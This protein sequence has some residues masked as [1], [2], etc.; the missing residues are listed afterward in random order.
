F[1]KVFSYPH[2]YKKQKNPCSNGSEKTVFKLQNLILFY[3][4]PRKKQA[5]FSSEAWD[6]FRLYVH[7]AYINHEIAQF[8]ITILQHTKTRSRQMSFP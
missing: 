5:L 1:F 8:Y 3:R 2:E 7:F 6:A 4:I